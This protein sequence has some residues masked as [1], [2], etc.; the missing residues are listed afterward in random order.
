MDLNGSTQ[1]D[2]PFTL[3]I[4]NEWQLE[5]AAKFGHNSALFIDATFGTIQTQV[6]IFPLCP[7]H[8]MK[9]HPKL[10]VLQII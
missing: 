10:Y 4:Q 6:C 1:S 5:M 9:V 2:A 8:Y 7:S 3:G